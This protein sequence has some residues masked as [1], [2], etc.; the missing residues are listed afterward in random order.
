ML[1]VSKRVARAT[2]RR[3][4]RR[5]FTLVELLVVLGILA[6]M[7]TMA[8]PVFLKR[9]PTTAARGAVL[10]LKSTLSLARQWA[11]TR[12]H[13]TYVVFPEDDSSVFTGA[14]HLAVTA[15][16]GYNIMT[17]EDGWL[18]EWQF[19][20]IGFVFSRNSKHG[21]NE[22]LFIGNEV[23]VF[24]FP[25]PFPFTNSPP[26]DMRCVSFTPNGRLN[27]TGG[28]TLQVVFTAGTID[29]NTNGTVSAYMPAANAPAFG[30]RIRPLTGRMTAVEYK[31]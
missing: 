24:R 30:V 21:G 11:V 25:V 8:V 12:R 13:T 22:N 7:M 5:S 28:T 15:M 18:G 6:L 3:I 31:P 9:S 17:K 29:A 2:D 20:P 23:G 26:R 27:Q 1:A 14:P 16:R 19:L 4:G 10:Q